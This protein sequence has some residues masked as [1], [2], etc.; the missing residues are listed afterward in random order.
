MWEVI[1][2]SRESRMWSWVEQS[3]SEGN[4]IVKV[5]LWDPEFDIWIRGSWPGLQGLTMI[6]LVDRIEERS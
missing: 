1:V 2:S 4:F 3:G 6:G 5:L